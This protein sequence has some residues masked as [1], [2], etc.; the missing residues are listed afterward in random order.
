MNENLWQKKV[1]SQKIWFLQFLSKITLNISNFCFKNIGN[2][3]KGKIFK[4]KS[5]KS[6]ELSPWKSEE[7]YGHGLRNLFNENGKKKKNRKPPNFWLIFKN[8]LR[9]ICGYYWYSSMQEYQTNI[10]NNM[11]KS[12]KKWDFCIFMHSQWFCSKN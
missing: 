4:G 6:L 5:F 7:N 8:S 9:D 11:H 10:F 12:L 2:E 1:F 3:L